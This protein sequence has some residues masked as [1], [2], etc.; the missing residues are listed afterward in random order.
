M[1]ASQRTAAQALRH[2]F[3]PSQKSNGMRQ[4]QHRC[5]DRWRHRAHRSGRIRRHGAVVWRRRR[6]I[7][8][9]ALLCIVR[10]SPGAP[11]RLCQWTCSIRSRGC[12]ST[13]MRRP[14]RAD[15]LQHHRPWEAAPSG[16]SRTRPHP[17][18]SREEPQVQI[19]LHR[20]CHLRLSTRS[21]ARRP[22]RAVVPLASFHRV[23]RLLPRAS[24]RA[25]SSSTAMRSRRADPRRRT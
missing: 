19:F 21:S 5:C 16:P 7:T 2:A 15:G 22:P 9:R 25:A 3:K 20:V 12:H 10:R 24:C 4:Y 8:C 13:P 23:R 6:C 1:Q 14:S 17:L 18:L 11:S